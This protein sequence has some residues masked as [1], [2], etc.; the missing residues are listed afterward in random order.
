MN[1]NITDE[2][3][4]YEC[5]NPWLF[6]FLEGCNYFYL[7]HFDGWVLVDEYVIAIQNFYLVACGHALLLLQQQ[8]P[9][10]IVFSHAISELFLYPQNRNTVS[11]WGGSSTHP[12]FTLK[13]RS[14]GTTRFSAP[15]SL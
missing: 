10:G 12:S 9:E 5:M 2:N 8:L 7:Q 6:D 3:S 15:I 4:E 11:E 1:N 14:V 13:V